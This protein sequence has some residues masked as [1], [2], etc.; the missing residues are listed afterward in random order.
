MRRPCTTRWISGLAFA[1][2]SL[3]LAG[4]LHAAA[5]EP[6]LKLGIIGP[7]SGQGAG[8]AQQVFD[9]FSLG[10]EASGG[11]VGGLKTTVIRE[12]D[13]LKPDVGLQ[14]ANKLIERDKVD[15]IFG[16]H[17]SNVMLAAYRTII[18]H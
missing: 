3:T 18:D 16:P 9:G 5:Q 17:Y 11:K 13:Q 15:V 2:T 6:E 1:V 8:A 10:I 12:D 4:G 7:F 14:A